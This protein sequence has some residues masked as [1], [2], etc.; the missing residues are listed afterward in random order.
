[1][2]GQIDAFFAKYPPAVAALGRAARRTMRQLLPRWNEFVYDNYN[3]LVFGFGPTDRPSD[4]VFSIALYPR[5][6][7]LFFL[8]GVSLQDPDKL[9]SGSGS[10]VRSLMLKSAKD[11]DSAP[12]RA[13]MAQ[14]KRGLRPPPGAKGQTEI[15]SVSTRQ[16][17]RRPS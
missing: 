12:V 14:A 2:A 8:D 16:R 1:V 5:W 13:L 7:R 11:L 6:V 17:P 4:A 10:A 9:L 3:A 15:R